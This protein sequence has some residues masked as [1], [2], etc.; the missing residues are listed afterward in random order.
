VAICT[1]CTA[2]FMKEIR[3]INETLAEIGPVRNELALPA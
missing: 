2:A 3:L 1:V